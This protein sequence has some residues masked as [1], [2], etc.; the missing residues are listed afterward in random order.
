MVDRSKGIL[1]L[2]VLLLAFGPVSVAQQDSTTDPVAVPKL[3]DIS[4]DQIDAFVKD[5]EDPAAREQLIQQ[6]TTLAQIKSANT[7]GSEV[8]DATADLLQAASKRVEVAKSYFKTFLERIN[9]LPQTYDWLRKQFEDPKTRQ[10]W[11][12]TLLNLVIIL[13]AGY[14]AYFLL[15]LLL[16]H[17]RRVLARQTPES[18]AVSGLLLFVVLLLDILSIVAF[19][20]AAYVTLGFVDP[21]QQI[22]LVALAWINGAVITRLLLA[23]ARM[24]FAPK[25]PRLRLFP[26]HDRSA[27]YG[28][29]WTRRFAFTSVYGYFALQAALLLGLPTITYSGALYLLGLLIAL[30]V[31][32]FIW[33]N[34]APVA[35]IIR[36]QQDEQVKFQG[37]RNRLAQFWFLLAALYVLMLYGIWVLGVDGGF[38]FLLRAT[39]ATLLILIV[40]HLLWRLLQKVFS[41]GFHIPWLENYLPGLQTRFNRYIPI[42]R[43]GVGWLIY[44]LVAVAIL[45]AWGIDAFAWLSSE[46][47]RVLGATIATILAIVVVSFLIWELAGALIEGYLAKTERRGQ[48][49]VQSNRTR[50]LLALAQNALMVVLAVLSTL[51]ILAQLG[52]NIAPLLAGAG[53]LGVAVGFGSQKLVQDV[54]TGAFILFEDLISVG[55]VVNVGDKDGIVEAVSMRTVRLRNLAGVVHTVPYSAITTVSNLTKDFSYYLLDVA[56]AYREDADQVMELLSQIGSE[57][58]QD[59]RFMHRILAPLE[60]LGVD[61]FADSAVIIK[62]RIKTLPIEQWSVGREFNRRMKKRFD[63]QNIEIPFPHRTLYFGVDKQGEAPPARLNVNPDTR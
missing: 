14:L 8:Q 54:I 13:G 4:P 9:A 18:K 55:D 3:P 10:V 39:L 28:F 12:K 51:L 46:P 50:T 36:G 24:V 11:G 26:L 19:A 35:Q 47:G 56:I 61:A 27:H 37:F 31:L 16:W 17:P 30:L 21:I 29:V 57:M 48:N 43:W 62:A 6:L 5:L 15:C 52:V 2:F 44:G 59:S 38:F 1:L 58:Q 63:E 40:G 22:R 41:R 42:L 25:M 7:Q 45:Q 34:R 53:V 60:I 33:R 49:R 20:V 32:V 23:I